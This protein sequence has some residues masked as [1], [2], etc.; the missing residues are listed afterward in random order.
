[1][2]ND[3]SSEERFTGSDSADNLGEFSMNE[4]KAARLNRTIET[5]AEQHRPLVSVLRGL[6]TMLE[7]SPP[8][9]GDL[10][11]RLNRVAETLEAHIAEEESGDLIR[12]VPEAFEEARGELETLQKEHSPF[13]EAIRQLAADTRGAEA[14]QMSTQLSVRIRSLIADIR[15]H[16]ARELALLQT[17]VGE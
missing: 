9:Q 17:L 11:R 10:E 7:A 12:W 5:L 1:M 8:A 6:E 3:D 4:E 15:Q 14:V 13:V 16:E 2:S